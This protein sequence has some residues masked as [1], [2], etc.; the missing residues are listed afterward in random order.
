[1]DENHNDTDL[2]PIKNVHQ[3]NALEEFE[4]YKAFKIIMKQRTAF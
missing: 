2:E 1:M 4:I 3:R